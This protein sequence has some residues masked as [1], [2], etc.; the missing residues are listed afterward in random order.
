VGVD[1]KAGHLLDLARD[2]AS[3]VVAE[4]LVEPRRREVRFRTGRT[5]LI[6]CRIGNRVAP[7]SVRA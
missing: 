4:V 1:L 5:G 7:T 6:E 3:S 2:G